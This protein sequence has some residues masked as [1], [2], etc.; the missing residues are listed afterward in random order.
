MKFYFDRLFSSLSP[1]A[2]ADKNNLHNSISYQQ[3]NRQIRAQIISQPH[4][5]THSPCEAKG[6]KYNSAHSIAMN[7]Y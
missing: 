4:F 3:V 6:R 1:K 7:F 2:G 5:I